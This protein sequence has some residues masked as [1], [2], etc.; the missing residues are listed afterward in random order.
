MIAPGTCGELVQG[1]I[2][3]AHFLVTCPVD[4][5]SKVSVTLYEEAIGVHGPADC[6]K[7]IEAIGRT[8]ADLGAPSVG[9]ELRIESDLPRGKGMA[10]ST[11]DVAGAIAATGLVLGVSVPPETV[12]R[13]AASIE[14]SDGIMFPGIVVC[15]HRQGRLIENLGEAPAI[16]IVAL[17]FGGTVDTVD[18][19]RVDRSAKFAAFATQFRDCLA[20]AR[21]GILFADLSLLGAA[22]TAS[23]RINQSIL[24]KRHLDSVLDYAQSI[25][26]A[27]VNVAHSG[28][29]IGLLLERSHKSADI[30]SEVPGL[31]PGLQTAYRLRLVGGGLRQVP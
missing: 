15:D 31:F 29:L 20:M 1:F 19:N 12:A 25:H 16:D 13:I 2:D 14:P 4:L 26:A 18:F 24:Y 30:L 9:V 10:S 21:Q 23:S 27:G 6:S 5:H 3:G 8:L 7:A 17:D 28:T 22:A 11:A